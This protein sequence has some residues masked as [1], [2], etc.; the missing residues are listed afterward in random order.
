MSS[1][2]CTQKLLHADANGNFACSHQ[3]EIAHHVRDTFAIIQC[4]CANKMYGPV[5]LSTCFAFWRC[6]HKAFVICTGDN[7]KPTPDGQQT[8]TRFCLTKRGC[9]KQTSLSTTPC[10]QQPFRIT[11]LPRSPPPTLTLTLSPE[12]Q[13]HQLSSGSCTQT[14]KAAAQS[15]QATSGDLS[16]WPNAWQL[17]PRQVKRKSMLLNQG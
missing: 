11:I 7:G 6:R 16:T 10:S 9:F 15:C 4:D 13:T 5:Q 17:Q 3:T 8:S 14:L 2:Q 1:M 12:P